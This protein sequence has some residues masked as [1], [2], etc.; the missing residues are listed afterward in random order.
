MYKFYLL[1]FL[2]FSL[3]LSGCGQKTSALNYFEEDPLSAN[4]IQYT[5]KRDLNYKNETKTLLFAT[6]LNKINKKYE[7]DKF[8]SFIIGIHLVNK[9][10]HDLIKNNYK[11]FLN[12]ETPISM[13]KLDNNSKLVKSIPLKNN[14]ANYYLVHFNKK[15][16][17]R[18][19]NL[20]LTH[21]TFGQI[22]LDFQK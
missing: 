7:T 22:F 9:D 16:D 18:L 10:N 19:L 1:S 4:A 11:L 6:Y 15:E 21:P 17:S 12:D 2:L 5:K 8:N 3:L 20:K 14:W 13:T